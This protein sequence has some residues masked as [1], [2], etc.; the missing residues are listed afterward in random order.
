MFNN[1]EG[2]V[3]DTY[4]IGTGVNKISFRTNNGVP[5]W[6]GYSD[7]AYI[8]FYNK[9]FSTSAADIKMAGTQSLG[10]L[11]TLC[12]ADHVHP[13]DTSSVPYTGGNTITNNNVNNMFSRSR[14]LDVLNQISTA[15]GGSSYIK[16]AVFFDET[17]AITTLKDRSVNLANVTLSANA[18]TL[19][20]SIVGDCRY[21]NFSGG[22]T[23]DFDDAADLSFGNGTAD[24]P[25][26]IVALVNMNTTGINR[27]LC[28]QDGD[29]TLASE[30]E[31][32]IGYNTDALMFRSFSQGNGAIPRGRQTGALTAN[33]GAFHVYSGTCAGT[34]LVGGYKI[35]DNGTRIDTTDNS[36]GIYVAM[37]N[38]TAKAGNYLNNSGSKI[39]KGSYK[40]GAIF[41]FNIELTA[42]QS[43]SIS[44]ILLCYTGQDTAFL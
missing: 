13:T 18:S 36:G 33:V 12:R 26:S 5:E 38:T 15:V 10:S 19:S 3:K 8:P 43:K 16:R 2:T 14:Q 23:F 37:S 27:I 32:T 31:F 41:V 17:G 34:G 24:T 39:Q 7:V 1:S 21:L 28:K 44:N 9:S 4:S 29:M 22:A 20:P 30:W 35:Y 40:G 42:A 6:K 25:F 11:N